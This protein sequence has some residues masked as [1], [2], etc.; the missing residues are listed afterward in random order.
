VTIG[1]NNGTG[2]NYSGVIANNTSGTGTVAL[3][4]TGTGTITLSGTNTYTGATTVNAGTLLVNGS[5]AASS[6]V[7]VNNSG[8]TLGG[9][10]TINGTVTVGSGANLLGGTGSAA[11]GTLTLANSLTLSSGSIIELALGASG[12]HSTLARTGGTWSFATSQAFTFINLGAQ[13]GSYT[14]II[15]GL[16]SDPGGETGW[17]ITDTGW[18]GNFTYNAGNINLSVVAVPE[19]STWI[20]GALALGAVGWAQRRR[21]FRALKRK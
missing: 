15:T 8:T 13:P 12:A 6:A 5:T 18:I 9:T 7:S 21:F 14:N 2:G 3:T 10:G 17:T 4:K 20:A 16:G 11:S 19:P 1:N